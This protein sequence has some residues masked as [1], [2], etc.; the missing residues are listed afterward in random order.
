[1]MVA[2]KIFQQPRQPIKVLATP[3]PGG[4]ARWEGGWT[5][6]V[7]GRSDFFTPFRAAGWAAGP[8]LIFL[9]PGNGVC[10]S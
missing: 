3:I 7:L 6:L 8:T 5:G 4:M 9:N 2:G 10:S 1:M